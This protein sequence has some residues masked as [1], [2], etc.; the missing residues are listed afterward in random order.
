MR[1]IAAVAAY[2]LRGRSGSRYGALVCTSGAMSSSASRCPA[3]M[4]GMRSA[5]LQQTTASVAMTLCQLVQTLLRLMHIISDG[6]LCVAA[7]SLPPRGHRQTDNDVKA[8]SNSICC[9]HV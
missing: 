8:Y 3:A 7:P 6:G 1:G 5:A 4:A 9:L 2:I